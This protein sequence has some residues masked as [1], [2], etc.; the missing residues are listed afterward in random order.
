MKAAIVATFNKQ[1][2]TDQ[3]EIFV[4]AE[5]RKLTFYMSVNKNCLILLIF[6]L[7]SK[8]KK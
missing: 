4:N 2:V 5:N 7:I 1:N 3:L 6:K 8:I